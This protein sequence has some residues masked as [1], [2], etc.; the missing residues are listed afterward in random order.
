LI[1]NLKYFCALLF[2][3]STLVNCQQ[4]ENLKN[5]FKLG[6]DVFVEEQLGLLNGKKVGLVINHT[7]LLSN[8]THILDTLLSLNVNVSSIFSPEHGLYGDFERGKSITDSKVSGIPVYSLHGNFEKPTDDMLNNLD[9]IIYDIQDLGVRFYTYV[10]TLYYVLESA[11][12]NNIPIIVIDRP[13]PNGGLNVAGP[14]LKDSYKSFIGSTEIPVLYG[15]T[16]GELAR[17]YLNEFILN[18]SYELTVIE[19]QNWN[20]EMNWDET[21]IKWI[22]P[23]PNIP[24]AQTAIVYPGICF[25]EGTNISEGRGTQRPFLQIGAPFISSE[26]LIIEMSKSIDKSFE[27]KPISFTPISMKIYSEHPKYKNKICYGISIKIN[28]DKEFDAL[29]FGVRLIY[30]LHKL[31]PGHFKFDT[32]HFDL[33]AGTNQLRKSILENQTPDFIINSWQNELNKFKSIREKYLLY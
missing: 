7:S 1:F 22:P 24:D 26:E 14:V 6:A 8:G 30:N 17:L 9:L 15:L 4:S 3:S 29:A 27:L 28:D 31:Y 12:E 11:V 32:N 23:S 2:I 25:L 5:N 21:G 16:T 13:N 10:T 33:L 18:S 19:M 20:R